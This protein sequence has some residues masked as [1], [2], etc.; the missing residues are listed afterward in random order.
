[1]TPSLSLDEL[2]VDDADEMVDVL[3]PTALYEFT[4]GSPPTLD[5]LRG[6]YQA[7]V[8]GSGLL[9]EEWLNWIVRIDDVA[10]G[11]VQAT[12]VGSTAT[13]AWVIGTPWQGRGHATAAVGA[14]IRVLVAQGVDAFDAWIAPGHRASERVASRVGLVVT[15][16][17]DD[18]GEVHWVSG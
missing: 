15:D 14:M 4:G 2:H 7:Q 9:D 16:Q 18:D 5:E 1:M 8:G 11:F 6:R 17:L 3:A 13:L 12:V 10:V